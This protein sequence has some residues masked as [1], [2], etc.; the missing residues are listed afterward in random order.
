[1]TTPFVYSP[2][3]LSWPRLLYQD[4]DVVVIEKPAGLLSNPGKGPALADSVQSRLAQQ[5]DSLYLVHRLDLATSGLMVFALRRKA[6]AELKAQFANRLVEK[7][8]LAVVA[9][10]PKAHSGS[11]QLPL[12]ADLTQPP[13]NKV[14]QQHGKAALTHYQQLWSDGSRSLLQ[15]KPVT[16]RS[17]QLRVHLLALGHP[18][19]GDT[20][21]GEPATQ[22]AA[23]RMLLHACALSFL[24]PYSAERLHF[25]L[26]PDWAAYAVPREIQ[27]QRWQAQPATN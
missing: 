8:Y 1:M 5:F 11:I 12:C 16:G 9:G 20:L 27:L 23:D 15:L 21:Y 19:L 18:I 14:C 6:E 2:P 7:T 4:K 17:H 13:K 10:Q 24:Q 26:L 22:Q 25:S 3:D